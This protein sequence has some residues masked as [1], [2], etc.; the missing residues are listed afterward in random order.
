M[1]GADQKDVHKHEQ[2]YRLSFHDSSLR[3]YIIKLIST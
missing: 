1:T 3:C 2:I